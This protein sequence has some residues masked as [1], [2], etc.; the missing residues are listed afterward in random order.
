ME[1]LNLMVSLTHF[2]NTQPTIPP[3]QPKRRATKRGNEPQH[4]HET[5]TA[6]RAIRWLR[7]AGAR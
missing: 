3:K 5:S 4:A 6:R 2:G 1:P 7:T